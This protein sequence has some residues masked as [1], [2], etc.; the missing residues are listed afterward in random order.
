MRPPRTIHITPVLRFRPTCTL[1][2]L[3]RWCGALRDRLLLCLQNRL[4]T[5]GRSWASCYRCA[6]PLSCCCVLCARASPRVL[7]LVVSA[8]CVPAVCCGAAARGSERAPPARRLDDGRDTQP[9]RHFAP[10][11]SPPPRASAGRRTTTATASTPVAQR[12]PHSTSRRQ[13][14]RRHTRLG[15]RHSPRTRSA[16]RGRRCETANHRRAHQP[17]RQPDDS[18]EQR[19]RRPGPG[20]AAA[21][22]RRR[23]AQPARLLELRSMGRGRPRGRGRREVTQTTH[24]SVIDR[25]TA[26][27]HNDAHHARVAIQRTRRDRARHCTAGTR[28]SDPIILIGR[29]FHHSRCSSSCSRQKARTRTRCTEARYQRSSTRVQ[30]L[31][32][33]RTH[34]GSVFRETWTPEDGSGSFCTSCNRSTF[35]DF[36]LHRIFHCCLHCSCCCCCAHCCSCRCLSSCVQA[37]RPLSSSMGEPRINEDPRREGAEATAIQAARAR[38][39]R[40]AQRRQDSGAESRSTTTQAHAAHTCCFPWRGQAMD[41]IRTAAALRCAAGDLRCG[42]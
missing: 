10:S 15:R 36:C 17:Q 35:C 39:S 19:L 9:R 8:V 20:C 16:L 40:H 21:K 5:G 23:G 29:R 14:M 24:D 25:R 1:W 34:G 2:P 18:A 30:L 3:V 26:H 32:Q 33:E 7:P 37:Q 4:S 38:D 12:T 22:A 42:R 31:S 6:C 13:H 27:R 11:P 28:R 41:A